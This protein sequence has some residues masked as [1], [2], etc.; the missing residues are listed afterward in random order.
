MESVAGKRAKLV[1]RAAPSTEMLT[2]FADTEKAK[3]LLNFQPTVTMEEG[4]ER[5]WNWF[6]DQNNAADARHQLPS[7]HMKLAAAPTVTH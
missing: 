5:F 6:V 7:I 3:R 2:T 1:S 4:I